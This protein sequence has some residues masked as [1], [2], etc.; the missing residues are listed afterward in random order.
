[1]AVISAS[2]ERVGEIAPGMV[3]SEGAVVRIC[4]L[5]KKSFGENF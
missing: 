4:Q 2:A 5:L 3:V 1:L